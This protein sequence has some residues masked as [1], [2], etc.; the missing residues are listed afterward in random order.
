NTQTGRQT[1]QIVEQFVFLIT[2]SHKLAAL[3]LYC[4]QIL[5][6]QRDIKKDR[7]THAVSQYRPHY[8]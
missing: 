4:K 6:R 5:T 1:G 3:V 7:L 8:F 2:H